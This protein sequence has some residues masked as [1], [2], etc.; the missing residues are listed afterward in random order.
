MPDNDSL[1]PLA[2]DVVNVRYGVNVS[3]VNV[4]DVLAIMPIGSS[5][6]EVGLVG[7]IHNSRN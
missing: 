4:A 2:S 1:L 3:F 6:S 7:F 5:R